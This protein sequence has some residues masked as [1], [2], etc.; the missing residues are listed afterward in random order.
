MP[1]LSDKE[2]VSSKEIAEGLLMFCKKFSEG[3]Q[4]ELTPILKDAGIFLNEKQKERLKF[5]MRIM[6]LWIVS[7]A[8]AHDKRV[9]D[10]MHKMFIFRIADSYEIKDRRNEVAEKVEERIQQA[11]KKYYD[12]WDDDS[13]GNQAI[14]SGVILEQLLNEG[15]PDKKFLNMRLSFPVN[16]HVLETMKSV[17][18]Y[19]NQFEIR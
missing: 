7:K 16:L 9:L 3:L 5:E 12:A 10:E 6:N 13:D 18:D 15:K 4:E 2:R 8:L 19:R 17:L 1:N 11:Y 14:L